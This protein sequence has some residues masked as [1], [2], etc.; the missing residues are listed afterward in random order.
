MVGT[1]EVASGEKKDVVMNLSIEIPNLSSFLERDRLGRPEPMLVSDGDLV[2]KESPI[3]D[4]IRKFKVRAGRN[5]SYLRLRRDPV[6]A[7]RERRVLEYRLELEEE[8]GP[9]FVFVGDKILRDD[10]KVDVWEDAAHL[11]F[12]LNDDNRKTTVLRGSL[13]LIVDDFLSHQLPGMRATGTND[14]SRQ[15]WALAAFGAYFFGHLVDVYMPEHRLVLDTA[16]SA[17]RTLHA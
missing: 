4:P 12:S 13:E 9:P 6:A 2:L 1:A 10:E 15:S 5:R 14:A 11:E 16:K 3:S 8:S 7:G 17:I